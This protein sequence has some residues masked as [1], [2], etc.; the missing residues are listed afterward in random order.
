MAG[1]TNTLN[2][3]LIRKNIARQ[4]RQ[5]RAVVALIY[6]TWRRRVMMYTCLT[7]LLI[8]ASVDTTPVRQRCCRRFERN[9]GW[10]ALVWNQYSDKRFTKTFRV[11]RPTF[12]FILDRIRHA[13]QHKTVNEEPISPECRLGICLYRLARGDYYYTIAEMV[14][15][16]VATVCLIVKEVTEAIIANLWNLSVEQHMPRTKEDFEGKILDMEELWQFPFCWAAIDGCHIPIKCPAGGLEACKKYHN[17]KNFY[18]VVLMAMVDSNYRFVWASCGF[19]GNSHDLII[20]QSTE[21]WNNITEKGAIPNIGQTVGTTTIYP[22]ILGD[23]AFPLQSWLMKPY[24]NAVLTNEQKNFNYRLSRARMVTEGAYGQ[25]KGRW[26][27]LI[28][29]NESEVDQV[30]TT[31][32]ACVV[33]HN[34]CI[35]RGKQCQESLISLLIL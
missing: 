4:N 34:I 8:L 17:F 25:M 9:N 22:L 21:L 5:R 35:D 23:S 2:L 26:R 20:F 18:S 10:W 29:K 32:L 33:L 30:K 7:T 19:P 31:A 15:L 6:A 27:V 24:T 16:G 11:S 28:W 3:Q 1:W 13:I 12:T 14:G